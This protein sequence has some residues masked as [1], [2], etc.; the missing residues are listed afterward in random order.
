MYGA[1]LAVTDFA[2]HAE[3][4]RTTKTYDERRFL[5]L[6]NGDAIINKAQRYFEAA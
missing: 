6:M 5:N 4:L 1:Y 2:S 3:P